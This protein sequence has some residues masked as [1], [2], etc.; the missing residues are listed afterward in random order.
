NELNTPLQDRIKRAV[1]IVAA[2]K[3]LSYVFDESAAIYSGG[4]ENITN[5]VIDQLLI[6]DSIEQEN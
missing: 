6:L 2:R 5:E 3:R 4:G 1:D